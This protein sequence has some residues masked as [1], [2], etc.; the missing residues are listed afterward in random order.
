MTDS[1]KLQYLTVVWTNNES[2]DSLPHYDFPHVR[3]EEVAGRK[4]VTV[5]DY[6]PAAD[7]TLWLLGLALREMGDE[8]QP[9]DTLDTMIARLD[10]PGQNV[11]PDT[12]D[13]AGRT[14]KS[15]QG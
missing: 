13:T 3:V 7:F 5:W 12:Q 2:E 14:P 8:P 9:D 10:N 6:E 15:S 4:L 11:R 1:T